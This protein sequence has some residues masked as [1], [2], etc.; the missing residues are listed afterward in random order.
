MKIRNMISEKTGRSI[1]NQYV[2]EDG[3]GNI[4]FQ[5]YQTTIAMIEKRGTIILDYEAENYSRTTS[6]YL[7][8]F[9]R[10][11]S[12]LQNGRKSVEQA[13]KEGLVIRAALSEL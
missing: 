7:Y 3:K 5:S 10:E 12:R 4:L 6:K 13:E 11:N 1:P 8:R 9:L 2:I